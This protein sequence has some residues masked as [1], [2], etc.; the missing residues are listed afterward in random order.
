MGE[1]DV[2]IRAGFGVHLFQNVLDRRL[3]A[4]A[5][6]LLRTAGLLHDSEDFA[7]DG[8]APVRP[9]RFSEATSVN[10]RMFCFIVRQ[11]K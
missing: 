6:G 1:G 10:D 11:N 8:P 7:D 4:V 9:E 3:L 5:A 2:R